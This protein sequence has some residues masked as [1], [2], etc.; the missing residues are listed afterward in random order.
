MCFK[1]TSAAC[2]GRTQL[3]IV[4][5][6]PRVDH[7]GPP[8]DPRVRPAHRQIRARFIHKYEP[9]GIYLHGPLAERVTRL[10]PGMPRQVPTGVHLSFAGLP[11]VR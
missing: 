1:K 7:H 11:G 4:K 3:I 9:R 2:L 6:S 8:R 10:L 5:L